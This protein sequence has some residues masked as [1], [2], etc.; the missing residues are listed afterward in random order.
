MITH[1][2]LSNCELGKFSRCVS[3]EFEPMHLIKCLHYILHLPLAVFVFSF[4]DSYFV[5]FKLT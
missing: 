1:L 4:P 2:L 5:F 3:S